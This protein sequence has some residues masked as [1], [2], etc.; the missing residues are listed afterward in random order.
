MNEGLSYYKM[1][2]LP[3]VGDYASFFAVQSMSDETVWSYIFGLTLPS[4]QRYGGEGMLGDG[5]DYEL[6]SGQLEMPR[7]VLEDGDEES[8]LD[9]FVY[10]NEPSVPTELV[11]IFS[12]DRRLLDIS[13]ILA[14]SPQMDIR[15][16]FLEECEIEDFD[17]FV[18]EDYNHL[19]EYAT[20]AGWSFD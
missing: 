17:D 16:A 1:L 11:D 2:D 8:F 3:D 15:E 7:E 9:D 20:S 19:M 5:I 18:E 6:A 14:G 13:E 12:M 10:E 4:T